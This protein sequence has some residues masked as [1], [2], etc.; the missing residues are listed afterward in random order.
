MKKLFIL[1]LFMVGVSSLPAQKFPDSLTFGLK[2][3]VQY[4]K[5]YESF[6]VSPYLNNIEADSAL[7]EYNL[8]SKFT[9]MEEYW[10]NYEWIV[11]PNKTP[12]GTTYLFKKL[13]EYER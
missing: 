1:F 10:I 9:K 7:Y 12:L 13:G 3:D 2:L 11:I 4:S 6:V 8:N 5:R